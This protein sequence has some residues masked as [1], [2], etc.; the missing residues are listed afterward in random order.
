MLVGIFNLIRAFPLDGGRILRAALIRWKRDYNTATKIAAKV[1]IA[2]SYGFMSVGFF[3]M[4]TGSF[5]G[6]VW[7]LLKVGFSI[8]ELNPIWVNRKLQGYHQTCN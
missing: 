4:I 8:A 6:G 7:L 2:I 1:G 5:I 3:F